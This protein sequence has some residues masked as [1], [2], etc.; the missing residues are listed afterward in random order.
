MLTKPNNLFHKYASTSV[1]INNR[2]DFGEKCNTIVLNLKIVTNTSST[3]NRNLKITFSAG[4]NYESVRGSETFNYYYA[5]ASSTSVVTKLYGGNF[6]KKV[7]IIPIP[8]NQTTAVNDN[9]KI[10]V[11]LPIKVYFRASNTF[12]NLFNIDIEGLFDI[13]TNI[14]LESVDISYEEIPS[15]FGEYKL[16]SVYDFTSITDSA[17]VNFPNGNIY[18]EIYE[19]SGSSGVELEKKIIYSFSDASITEPGHDIVTITLS[20]S[21]RNFDLI[22]I[23]CMNYL[24]GKPVDAHWTT[25]FPDNVW[26]N[27]NAE[28]NSIGDLFIYSYHGNYNIDGC[29]IDHTTLKYWKLQNEDVPNYY[30]CYVNRVIG[31]RIKEK[32]VRVLRSY[33]ASNKF[34]GGGLVA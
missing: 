18:P 34:K 29:F 25:V 12:R 7:Q 10:V 17:S 19:N 20:E 31:V 15:N 21:I 2:E 1:R 9:G 14:N 26:F 3:L 6:E 28:N 4:Y 16:G 22:Y 11:T 30:I 8:T 13:N 24:N 32:K 27:T 5:Q 33:F 23:E